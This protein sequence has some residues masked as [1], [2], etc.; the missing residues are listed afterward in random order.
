MESEFKIVL[1][2]E[3]VESIELYSQILG[4]SASD[5]VEEALQT[6]FSAIQTKMAQDSMID[7]NAQTNLGY[8]EFW[9]GV[10]L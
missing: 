4:K 8:D 9:N 3:T 7:D 5:L 6:Y 2:P 10:D 1:R